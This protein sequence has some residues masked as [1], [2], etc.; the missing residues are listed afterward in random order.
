MSKTSKFVDKVL[1]HVGRKKLVKRDYVLRGE[2]VGSRYFVAEPKPG[3]PGV[4][5]RTWFDHRQTAER[6]L[7][8]IGDDSGWWELGSLRTRARREPCE[9]WRLR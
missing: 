1:R 9:P 2:T 5:S 6:S 3:S 8:H 4:V 7:G